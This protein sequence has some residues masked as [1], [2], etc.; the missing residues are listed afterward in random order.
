VAVVRRIA[1]LG[2]ALA[3]DAARAAERGLGSVGGLEGALPPE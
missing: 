3:V 1:A 2:V